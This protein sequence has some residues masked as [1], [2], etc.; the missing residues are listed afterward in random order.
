MAFS[1]D[2]PRSQINPEA[3]EIYAMHSISLHRARIVLLFGPSGFLPELQKAGVKG[4][5]KMM[6]GGRVITLKESGKETTEL[7]ALFCLTFKYTMGTAI[8]IK[9]QIR[10]TNTTVRL[11]FTLK[12]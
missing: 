3:A 9:A 11:K 6:I 2:W 10:R 8:P 5:V 4:R 7:N 12:C 1:S